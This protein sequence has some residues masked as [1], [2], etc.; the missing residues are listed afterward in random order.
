MG[1]SYLR[2]TTDGRVRHVYGICDSGN[3]QESGATEDLDAGVEH[4]QSLRGALT[5]TRF[6]DQSVRCRPEKTQRL[7]PRRSPRSFVRSTKNSNVPIE[8]EH[9]F[10]CIHLEQS[11]HLKVASDPNNQRYQLSAILTSTGI[12]WKETS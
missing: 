7:F 4:V 3:G 8:M 12:P 11:C 2:S 10:Y 9:T 6:L 5:T 1:P